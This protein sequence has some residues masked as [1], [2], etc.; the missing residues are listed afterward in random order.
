MGQ[1]TQTHCLSLILLT[2][3]IRARLTGLDSGA[4]SMVFMVR[5]STSERAHAFHGSLNHLEVRG[6][7]R[8]FC[9]MHLGGRPIAG[10]YWAVPLTK[11]PLQISLCSPHPSYFSQSSLR[12]LRCPRLSEWVTPIRRVKDLAAMRFIKSFLGPLVAS[13]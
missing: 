11:S 1:I 13:G 3:V 2:T 4:Y 8:F 5:A 10:V 9:R 12:C 7:C 6:V